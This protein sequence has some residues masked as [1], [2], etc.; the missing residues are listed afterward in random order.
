M[1][2]IN[3][4]FLKQI[5]RMYEYKMWFIEKV[6]RNTENNNFEIDWKLNIELK[7]TSCQCQTNEVWTQKQNVEDW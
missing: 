6:N 7:N 4:V 5:S 1:T 3:R 2:I